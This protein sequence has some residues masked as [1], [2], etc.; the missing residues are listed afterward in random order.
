[1]IDRWADEVT[2][3]FDSPGWISSTA[4]FGCAKMRFFRV[5]ECGERSSPNPEKIRTCFCSNV[6]SCIVSSR[7][8]TANAAAAASLVDGG[9]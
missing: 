1:M 3:A 8:S 7:I 5:L 4:L 6:L 2:G 9:V